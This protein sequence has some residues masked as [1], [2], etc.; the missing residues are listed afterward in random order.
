M[1]QAGFV[2][3]RCKPYVP[4]GLS[5]GLRVPAPVR[6]A[7]IRQL[8]VLGFGRRLAQL[9]VNCGEGLPRWP[10]RGSLLRVV[11]MSSYSCLIKLGAVNWFNSLVILNTTLTVQGIRSPGD[12]GLA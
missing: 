5:L 10:C 7:R 4:G 11:C 2:I 8:F 3:F 6:Q 12:G 1:P 9:L